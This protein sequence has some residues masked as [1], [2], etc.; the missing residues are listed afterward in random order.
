MDTP[1][2]Q[3]PGLTV[4]APGSPP[5]PPPETLSARAGRAFAAYRGGDRTELS[6]LVDL[7]TPV[8]WHTARAQ[9]AP[10]EV[11]EDAV[12]TAWL[13]LVDHAD[14]IEQPGAVLGW[15][16]VT[17]KR[18]TWRLLRGRGG[19]VD[20]DALPERPAPGPGPE[21]EAVLTERQA[22]LWGHVRALSPRCQELLRIVAFA[23]R[24]DYR[25]IS[26]ALGM[27]VGS[28]GPTRG[29]CLE[30]LRA[31]LGADPRWAES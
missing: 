17:V 23:D 14:R 30:K 12:Q 16:V 5:A 7:L 24:P 3:T 6:T 10:A 26:Q 20:L 9:N 18:E 2:T 4:A 25:A 8:L 15:L 28:I 21:G 22:T 11:A 19:H 31:A 29:R 13:R 1:V 27:P